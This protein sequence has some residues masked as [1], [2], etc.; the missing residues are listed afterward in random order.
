MK[1][2]CWIQINVFCS[3][4]RVQLVGDEP[5]HALLFEIKSK[6][7]VL[8]EKILPVLGGFHTVCA[9][10]S[11]IHQGFRG[12]GHKDLAVA[13]VMIEPGSVDDAVKGGHYKREMRIHKL[14]FEPLVCLLIEQGES[15]GLSRSIKAKL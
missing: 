12:S 10:L 11:V 1:E 14:T 15:N 13:A 3:T 7:V 9:F 8:F 4:C 5:V 6:N 2:S